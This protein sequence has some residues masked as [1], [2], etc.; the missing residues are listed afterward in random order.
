MQAGLLPVDE[1]QEM[2]DLVAVVHGFVSGE[3]AV[4]VA[5]PG[6]DDVFLGEVVGVHEW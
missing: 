6:D 2:G 3:A 1:M 5:C 4:L